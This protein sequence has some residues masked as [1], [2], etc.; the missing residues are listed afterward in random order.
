MHEPSRQAQ[1]GLDLRVRERI[2]PARRKHRERPEG[3]AKPF[4]RRLQIAIRLGSLGRRL[5]IGTALRQIEPSNRL[6][7]VVQK[8][9]GPA[10]LQHH[11]EIQRIVFVRDLQVLERILEIPFFE[12]FLTQ[13]FW[14][15]GPIRVRIR[16]RRAQPFPVMTWRS[17]RLR[18]QQ[19]KLGRS[20]RVVRRTF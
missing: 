8:I 2:V 13:C 17:H 5:R 6:R 12:A 10:Q 16:P 14:V 7:V 20:G 4:E 3:G 15:C 1:L 19:P 18:F 9:V 11:F